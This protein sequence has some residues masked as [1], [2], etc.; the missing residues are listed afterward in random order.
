MKRRLIF[1][2]LLNI[3]LPLNALWLVN[4]PS[5]VIS[6]TPVENGHIE[7]IIRYGTAVKVDQEENGWVHV[8]YPGWHGWVQKEKLLEV[9]EDE[10]HPKQAFVG[11]RGAYVFGVADTEWGPMMHLPFET[12][13]E[14]VEELPQA[15]RRWVLV[16]LQQ[17]QTGY[18]QRSQ[19]TFSP[20]TLTLTEMIGFAHQFLGIKYL[21][22]GTTSFGY[23]CSG[24]VQMLYRQ[25]GETLPR[26]S[27]QQAVDPRFTAVTKEEAQAGDLIFFKNSSGNVVH[28]GMVVDSKTFIHAFTKQESW[29]CLSSLTDERFGN[30]T[31]YFGFDI[32]RFQNKETRPAA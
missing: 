22:G 3:G 19:L 5:V 14:V 24:F 25:M 13:L 11:Y 32:Q 29:I 16:K 10:K 17:G 20:Q 23:D 30:G 8:T 28:V 26:N 4:E 7:D 2:A 12:P 15:N 21:W 27:N 9:D 6:T 31:F 18:V 1:A